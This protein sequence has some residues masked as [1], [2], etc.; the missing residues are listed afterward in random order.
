MVPAEGEAAGGWIKHAHVPGAGS[1]HCGRTRPAVQLTPGS[2][3]L[4]FDLLC[5]SEDP[6]LSRPCCCQTNHIQHL[7]PGPP[8]LRCHHVALTCFSRVADG[9]ALPISVESRHTDGIGSIRNQVVQEGI[10]N[11]SWNQ[12]LFEKKKCDNIN[13]ASSL[14]EPRARSFY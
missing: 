14:S 5:D 10:A 6:D 8:R 4:L 1:W 2:F 13:P 12:N 9:G 11:I 7:R 3:D